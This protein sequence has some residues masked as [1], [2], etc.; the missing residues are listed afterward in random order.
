MVPSSLLRTGHASY[1]SFST[2]VLPG[3]SRWAARH[4]RQHK[5]IQTIFRIS[6]FKLAQNY[7]VQVGIICL[8]QAGINCL[9]QAGLRNE[10]LKIAA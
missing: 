6:G 7:L 3:D 10:T 9:V 4:S 8:V 1:G 5:G 2:C